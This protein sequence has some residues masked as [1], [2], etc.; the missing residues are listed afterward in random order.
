MWHV[1]IDLH[2]QFVVIAAVRD[3][4]AVMEPVRIACGETED[5]V[6]AVLPLGRFRAVIE[7]SGGAL[8]LHRSY[9]AL[10]SGDAKALFVR[11]CQCFDL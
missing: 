8:R 7:S 1:G 3:N 10:V 5:I 6:N 4:G 9:A 2:R 11:T